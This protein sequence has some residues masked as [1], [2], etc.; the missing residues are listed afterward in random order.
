MNVNKCA[1]FFDELWLDICT[2]VLMLFANKKK[3]RSGV[4]KRKRQKKNVICASSINV[5]CT[6]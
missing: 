4:D 1:F 3:R 5:L 2:E 6:K